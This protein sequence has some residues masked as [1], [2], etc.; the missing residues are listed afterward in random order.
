MSGWLDFLTEYHIPIGRTAHKDIYIHC[1]FCGLEDPSFHLGLNLDGP[2]YGCWRDTSHRGHGPARLI[3]ELLLCS[4]EEAK[5]IAR[6]Y[7]TNLAFTETKALS[8]RQAI[9]PL[10]DFYKFGSKHILEGQFSQYLRDRGFDPSYICPRFDLRWCIRNKHYAYRVIC[11]IIQ[12]NQWYGWTARTIASTEPKRYL[13]AKEPE[14]PN[15]ITDFLFD[16]DNLKGGKSLIIA[17]GV[18]DAMAI[19]RCMLPGISATCLFGKTVSIRQRSLLTKVANNYERVL[20]SL[21]PDAVKDTLKLQSQLSWYIP[22]LATLMPLKKDYGSVSRAD[23]K[24]YL[25]KNA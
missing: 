7:F 14:C 5:L 21:D 20:I 8:E 10:T 23:L 11:P 22:N 17:E 16:W 13:A 19:I 4:L 15:S 2:S 18:F 6:N 1:P 24:G 12:H 3:K 9:Q 25:L